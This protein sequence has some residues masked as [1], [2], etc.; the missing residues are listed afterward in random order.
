MQEKNL[1]IFD[2][3]FFSFGCP[4]FF[5]RCVWGL[6]LMEWLKG[7]MGPALNKSLSKHQHHQVYLPTLY[8]V[9]GP[10]I[11]HWQARRC[12]IWHPPTSHPCTDCFLR[13]RQ[14]QDMKYICIQAIMVFD[15]YFGSTYETTQPTCESSQWTF[16]PQRISFLCKNIIKKKSVVR[17]LKAECGP[18]KQT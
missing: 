15:H 13:Q 1:K 6:P 14:G 2:W 3:P 8:L 9:L 12:K 10:F 11:Q 4:N 17:K 7:P 16:I 5:C 18:I